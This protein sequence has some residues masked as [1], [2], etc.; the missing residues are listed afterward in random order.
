MADI[1]LFKEVQQ[2]LEMVSAEIDPCAA[3]VSSFH[4]FKAGIANEI[5]SFK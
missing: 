4:S 5:S 3:D 1:Q 2:T